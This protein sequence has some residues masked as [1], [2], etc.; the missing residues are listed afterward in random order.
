M[1]KKRARG[2]RADEPARGRA[3]G[4]GGGDVV[5]ALK[6]MLPKD[7]AVIPVPKDA[8]VSVEVDVNEMAV[9]YTIALDAQTIIQSLVDRHEELPEM[10][11]GT[12]R[13]SWGF[14]H[15]V[16]GW[17]HKV[18]LHVGATKTVLDEKSEE[19]KDPD[20]SIGVAFLVVS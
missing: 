19:K 10:S 5:A 2:P 6:T 17:K 8:K 1:T 3:A 14:A 15:A 4:A 16:K 11:V 12:H 7:V 20:K 18:T 9:A 13:L